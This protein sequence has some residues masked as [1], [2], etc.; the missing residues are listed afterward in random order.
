MT[1]DMAS[2]NSSILPNVSEASMQMVHEVNELQEEVS[3]FCCIREDEQESSR[4]LAA[5]LQGQ[6]L[7]PCGADRMG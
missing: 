3:L 5:T 2:H 4:M 1:Q 6:E 7:R